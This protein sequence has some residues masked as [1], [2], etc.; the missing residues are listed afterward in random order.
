MS[1]HHQASTGSQATR[2]RADAPD[3]G[4]PDGEPGGPRPGVARL[5]AGLALGALVL[6]LGLVAK[7]GPVA[8]LDLQV[9]R[10]IASHDRVAPLTALAKVATDIGKPETVGV[11]LMIVV[12]I[13]LLLARRRL[14]A[15]KVF[16]I[17]GAAFTLA[18]IGKVLIGEH[19]PP[20]ALQLVPADASPSF[21]SGHATT[22]A[23]LAVALVVIATTLA[24]RVAA[25]ALGG[26]YA[27]SV[28]ASRV[29]LGDHYTLDVIGGMLCAIA[30]GLAITGLVALPA[31]QPWLRKLRL[32][33]P[34]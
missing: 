18:E 27:L 1:R 9:D 20:A 22:A 6:L 4:H 31:A 13:A 24:W 15:A 14:D 28:A 23:V 21:P 34:A 8:R 3:S 11:G 5:V 12:P 29:Y 30:A 25:L 19:R 16:V 32:S 2:P 17:F 33:P 7:L 26:L 10:H